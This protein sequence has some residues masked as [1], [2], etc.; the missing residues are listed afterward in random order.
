MKEFIKLVLRISF[1]HLYIHE[2]DKEL[3]KEYEGFFTAHDATEETATSSGSS[4]N[5]YNF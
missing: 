4:E 3:K 5:M 1:H 2:H